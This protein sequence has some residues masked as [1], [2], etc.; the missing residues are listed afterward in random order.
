MAKN[1]PRTTKN[2]ASLPPWVKKTS[3][4][5]KSIA[6]LKRKISRKSSLVKLLKLKRKE[7]QLRKNLVEDQ[8]EF[9][10][11]IFRARKFSDLQKYLR[12]IH[13]SSRFPETMKDE[14]EK[15]NDD[16]QKNM[17]FSDFFASVFPKSN[18]VDQNRT[19]AKKVYNPCERK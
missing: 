12:S 16:A 5:K 11:K 15:P 17:F 2:R 1:V 19:F 3:H 14:D 6:T 9:K 4:L 7:N 13:K 18:Q 10:E 8:V